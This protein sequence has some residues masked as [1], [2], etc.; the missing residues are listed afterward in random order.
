MIFV[1]CKLAL[2]NIYHQ[3]QIKKLYHLYLK[4]M[5]FSFNIQVYFVDLTLYCDTYEIKYYK[6]MHPEIALENCSECKSFFMMEEFESENIQNKRCPFC[7]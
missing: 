2:K 6:N 7:Q 5:Y 1:K 4:T 3:F